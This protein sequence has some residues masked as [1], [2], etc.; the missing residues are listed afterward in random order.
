MF[1]PN[2]DQRDRLYIRGRLGLKAGNGSERILSRIDGI[3]GRGKKE[4]AATINWCRRG[5]R[6]KT[7]AKSHR[8]YRDAVFGKSGPMMR[9]KE[10]ITSIR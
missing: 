1:D 2:R 6:G 3:I 5:I 4:K 9:E 10:T 8:G 7:M